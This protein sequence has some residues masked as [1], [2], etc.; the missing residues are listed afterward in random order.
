VGN[1]ELYRW[2]RH[3]DVSF[4]LLLLNQDGTPATGMAPTV[5]IRRVRE[6]YGSGL[7]GYWWNGTGF[8]DTVQRLAMTETDATNQPGWYGYGF[9][10]ASIGLAQEYLVFFEH[11]VAPVGSAAETHVFTDEIFVTEGQTA[12][13]TVT[14][15]TVL[16]NLEL[17]KD[18][19]TGLFDPE[20]ESLRG[21]ALA[22]LR[23]AGLS[24][25]NSLFDRIQLDEHNQPT[26]GRLRV[27]DAAQNVPA[28]PGGNETLGLLHEYQMVSTYAGQNVLVSFTMK[29]VL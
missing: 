29:R 24:R 9:P 22:S 16:G 12:P 20:T 3:A 14:N 26:A 23:A 2:P 4:R 19:G 28:T 1:Q 25:E 8:V 15:Q 17:I 11:T 13:V 5:Q 10:Q 6:L 21:L 7:D 27:F 18:G